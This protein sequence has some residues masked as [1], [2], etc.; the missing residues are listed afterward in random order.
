[1]V[2]P[3]AVYALWKCPG[4]VPNF[5]THK[6]VFSRLQN[7]ADLMLPGVMIPKAGFLNFNRDQACSINV[8]SNMCV[9]WGHEQCVN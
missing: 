8:S 2:K 1:M 9:S 4:F 7:G 5:T 6:F 3:L